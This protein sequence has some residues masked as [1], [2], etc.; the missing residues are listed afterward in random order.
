VVGH[1]KVDPVETLGLAP[2]KPLPYCGW[3][4]IPDQYGRSWADDEG[5]SRVPNRP[6]Q[7][8][9]MLLHTWPAPTQPPPV[10][11]RELRAAVAAGDGARVLAVVEGHD[12]D[13][14]L[15]QVGAAL[16]MALEQRREQAEP[17]TLSIINRLTW[18]AGAGDEVLAED[19]LARMRGEPLP[20][21][22]VP[23][24]LEMLATEREGDPEMSTGGYLDL[25]TGDVYD[26]NSTDPML[27]G[28]DAAIDVDDE[29]DRWLRLD[30]TGSRDGWHDMTA[31]VER[32]RDA[33][34]RKRMERAI[35]GRGAFRRFRELVHEE[36]L[37]EQW[38]AFSA[39]R[40]LG[41]A[42][43]LLAGEGFRVGRQSVR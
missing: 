41:R 5:H 6:D 35:E 37:A 2:K 20:G 40:Q 15:Q 23:V 19:L 9:P 27:V 24:D 11:L 4:S 22:V 43:E 18:R 33:G 38:Y 26:E 12:V 16:P 21:R 13:D 32:N 10:D 34:L 1:D 25:H 29:P 30:C 36:G 39:D 31:F 3:G 17:V 14:V 7:R 28:E 8:H 42:R